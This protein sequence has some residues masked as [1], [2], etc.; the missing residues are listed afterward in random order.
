M[1][2]WSGAPWPL[3]V[4]YGLGLGALA[5]TCLAAIASLVALAGLGQLSWNL[6][7]SRLPAWL[8][9][10]RADPEL[11]RW[12][13]VGLL[14]A[15]T[16]GLLVIMAIA[17]S[18]RPPLHGAARWAS[19][20]D[21]VRSGLRAAQGV[22][23]GRKNGRLLVSSGEE[24]VMLYAPTRSGKGVSVV[25]PNLLN[26][27]DSTVVLDIKRENWEATAGFRAAH[28]Q[29]VFLFD[30]L[31]Q[32]GRTAR[33][34]PLAH[35]DRDDPIAVMDEL[36]KLSVMLFPPPLRADPFWSEAARTGFIG[37]G[38][39]VA[40]GEQP[41]SLG[42]IYREL[43]DGDPRTRLPMAVKRRQAEGKPVSASCARALNDFCSTSDATF[44]GIKQTLTSRLN[45]FL[46]PRVCAATETSDF[47]LAQLR[48]RR[49]S[50]YLGVSPDN[51]A[52]VAPLYGLLFQQL[53]ERNARERP[54]ADQRQIKV[55]VVLDEFAR[56]GHVEAVA[57]GFS[58]IAGYG[59][60]LLPVLQS[61]AQLRGEYGVDLA[62]DIISNCAVEIAF[63]LKELHV[64]QELS[65]R[66]GY[67]TY[68]GRSRSRPSLLSRGHR[69]L[70]ES[71]QRRA[72]ML[73][74]ELMQMPSDRMVV[75]RAGLAPVL[76]RKITYWKERAFRD[77]VRPPPTPAA[78][79]N[80]AAASEARQT[81]EPGSATVFSAPLAKMH[82]P[83]E[84]DLSEPNAIDPVGATRE[85]QRR[86]TEAQVDQ[87]LQSPTRAKER[88][89]DSPD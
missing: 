5:A 14:S 10:F 72:L 79:S 7:I 53:I 20:A 4:A 77:R 13:G 52:R 76:G 74:Q 67:Y 11:R 26:W 47:D 6:Q 42:V 2:R 68:T 19:E 63:G 82:L 35:I 30:P 23:L 85:A 66:L 1:T 28:G 64:A 48:D 57:R 62:Q 25:I 32:D 9:Y 56:L 60:R 89:R 31:A 45:L 44:S 81:V 73:P 38:A 59:L 86:W 33:Y 65:E 55:L 75:L 8:W 83:V 3:K 18:Q 12:L 58:Y 36:Q 49:I 80:V 43:T 84:P 24:H 17:K 22:L 41:F 29:E 87:G 37:V 46:N 16:C 69:S 40:S 88:R 54:T 51:L 39:F 70:T 21:L 15:L 61:P 78:H 34:N 27:P 50:I 71:D